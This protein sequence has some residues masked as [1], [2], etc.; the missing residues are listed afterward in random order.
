MRSADVQLHIC[1]AAKKVNSCSEADSLQRT[2]DMNDSSKLHNE[3]SCLQLPSWTTHRSSSS[4]D[5]YLQDDIICPC[6]PK[7]L[8]QKQTVSDLTH[9]FWLVCM[10]MFHLHRIRAPRFLFFLLNESKINLVEILTGRNLLLASH[11]QTLCDGW[12][13]CWELQWTHVVHVQ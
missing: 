6:L 13:A 9:S 5:P 3:M 12:N 10:S 11:L 1:A 4:S 2:T 7:V 8:L